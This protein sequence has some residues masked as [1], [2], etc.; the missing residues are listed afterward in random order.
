[1]KRLF[2]A[3]LPWSFDDVRLNKLFSEIGPVVS[4]QV[5]LDRETNRSR[6]FGF[7]EMQSEADA[8]K[9]IEIINDS[10]VDGRKLVC[11]IAKPREDSRPKR[12]FHS[13][14]R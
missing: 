5:V 7:V 1:M 8:Q 13:K 9:A 14:R 2:I 10:E 3:N 6:G 12:E 11:N 4:A